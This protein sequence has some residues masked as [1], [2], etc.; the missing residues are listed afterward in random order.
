MTNWTR[1]RCPVSVLANHTRLATSAVRN[2]SS[3]SHLRISFIGASLGL[4]GSSR[5]I[6]LLGALSTSGI[7]S[8][9]VRTNSGVADESCCACLCN[10]TSSTVVGCCAV[11]ARGTGTSGVSTSRAI[12]LS[13]VTTTALRSC[14]AGFLLPEVSFYVIITEVSFR[15]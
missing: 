6:P 7:R 13:S 8:V 5:A 11:L 1:V 14:D 12:E 15:A 9:I 4:D 3:F 2:L 10:E